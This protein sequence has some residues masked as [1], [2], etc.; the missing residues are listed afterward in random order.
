MI[1]HCPTVSTDAPIARP[2]AAV[3]GLVLVQARL[4]EAVADGVELCGTLDELA[5][6]LGVEPDD[7][8]AAARELEAVGWVALS[9]GG[10]GTVTM[11][12]ADEEC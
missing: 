10:D 8:A 6:E 5:A 12:W 7:L 9:I 11:R 1:E 2:S 4:I 3:P